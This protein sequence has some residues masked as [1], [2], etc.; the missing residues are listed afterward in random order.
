MTPFLLREGRLYCFSNLRN[1]D[2]PFRELV[3]DPGKV[4]RAES[5]TW[6]SDE[7]LTPWY[8][9][10]LN[11]ALNKLTGW[12]GL[13][14]DREHNRY[15]FQ[16]PNPGKPLSV[17]YT[18]LN[19]AKSA[20]QAVWQPISKRTNTPRPYWNHLAAGLSFQRVG[21]DNWCLI[22][23]PEMRITKDGLTPIESAK[24]GGKVTRRKSRMFNYDLLEELQFWRDFL[25]DSSPR[26]VFPFEAGQHIIVSNR[27][28]ESDIEWPGIP[29]QYAK[30]FR[31]VERE[32]DLFTAAD[33][34]QLEEEYLD[35]EDE[36]D[37]A[38]IDE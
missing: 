25:S 1:Q 22:I 3:S 7:K 28:M 26:I 13:N 33:R 19:Q 21:R 34:E 15:F 16:P 29:E 14:L 6:W 20:R 37:E 36:W 18:P 12:R 27:L 9:S 24:I 38:E 4:H 31:N 11:R 10:L 8:I 2:G 5:A 32:E 35:H 23:R 17:E 30:P